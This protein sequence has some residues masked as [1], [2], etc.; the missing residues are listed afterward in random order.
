MK[1]LLKFLF[2]KKKPKQKEYFFE[3]VETPEEKVQKY[4]KK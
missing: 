1:H 4:L 3:V 2:G